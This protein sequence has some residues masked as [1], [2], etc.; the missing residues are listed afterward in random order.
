MRPNLLSQENYA[1][2]RT[3]G[4]LTALFALLAALVCIGLERDQYTKRRRLGARVVLIAV[5]A[6]SV[7]LGARNE[8]RL[9]VTPQSREWTLV[10]R[11]VAQ[12]PP[13]AAT[14]RFLA[15][16]EDGG[17]ITTRYGVR[18]EFAVPSTASAWADS[19]IVWL[20]A[21]EERRLQ[22]AHL[23]V[24]VTVAAKPVAGPRAA[25]VID[26]TVLASSR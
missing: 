15:P 5:A 23:R 7:I 20:A 21:K 17:P 14:V 24:Y 11:D 19:S 10:R 6:L 25:N 13:S 26:M 1:T 12:L 18:D 3:V 4:P 22:T 2:Y 8:A 9:I 16:T